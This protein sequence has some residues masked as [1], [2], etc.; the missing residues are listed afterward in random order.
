[1]EGVPDYVTIA[2]LRSRLGIGDTADDNELELACS[3]A[4]RAV[5]HYTRRVFWQTEPGVARTFAAETSGMVRLP[6]YSELVSATAVAT[7]ATGDGVYGTAW[8][9]GDWQLL[10]VNPDAGPEPRPYTMIRAVGALQFPHGRL[11]YGTRENRVQVTGVWGW[12]QVPSAVAQASA[13]LAQD[14]FKTKDSFG[15][16]AGFG[17]FGV[18][19]LR[20]NH[21]VMSLI[22]PYLD[23]YV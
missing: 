21:L 1:V 13:I 8:S 7:D 5:E 22:D 16:V 10:P 11:C 15:G 9:A 19:R 4:S 18:V 20:E 12:P 17:E 3:A 14:I 23:L 6:A 2:D